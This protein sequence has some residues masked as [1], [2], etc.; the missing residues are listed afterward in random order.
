[1]PRRV[2]FTGLALI[3]EPNHS[4]VICWVLEDRT[5]VV[6]ADQGDGE[7]LLVFRDLEE[8][9][10]FQERTGKEGCKLVGLSLEALRR[11]CNK[12][13]FGWVAIPESPIEQHMVTLFTAR[14]FIERLDEDLDK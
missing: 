2:C 10:G 7:S 5:G 4:T 1:V 8:A 13:D 3:M 14:A 12:Y 9:R 11:L 6:T